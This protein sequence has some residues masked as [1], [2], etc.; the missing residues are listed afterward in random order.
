MLH[1]PSILNSIIKL[2]ESN[3]SVEVQAIVLLVGVAAGWLLCASNQ[4]T[5]TR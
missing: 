3:S 5:L 4:S 1:L 2:E